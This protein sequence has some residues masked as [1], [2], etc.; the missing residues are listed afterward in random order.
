M[1][2]LGNPQLGV[3]DPGRPLPAVYGP[4]GEIKGYLSICEHC[5]GYYWFYCPCVAQR[6]KEQH[7]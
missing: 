1:T 6:L 2:T 7:P 3:A 5:G 4:N